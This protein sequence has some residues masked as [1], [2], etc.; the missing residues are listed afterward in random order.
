MGAEVGGVLVTAV[1]SLIVSHTGS[2]PAIHGEHEPWRYTLMSG[3]IPAI[4]LI[5]VRPFLPESPVWR[6][7]KAAGTLRR[8]SPPRPAET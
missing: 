8:P 4:P 5:V 3:V 6:E 1:Y 7:K 2:L